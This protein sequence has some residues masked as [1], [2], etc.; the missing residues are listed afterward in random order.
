[1]S[2][3]TRRQFLG[4]VASLL[5]LIDAA[6]RFFKPPEV[7]RREWSIKGVGELWTDNEWPEANTGRYFDYLKADDAD[8]ARRLT[9]ISTVL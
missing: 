1:M 5:T 9:E 6:R 8:L 4:F 3:H 2:T 7:V